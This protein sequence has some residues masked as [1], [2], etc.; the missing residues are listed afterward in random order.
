M[1]DKIKK[2]IELKDELREDYGIFYVAKHGCPEQPYAQISYEGFINLF[3]EGI[4]EE[5]FDSTEYPVK[6][7]KEVDGILFFTL[8]TEEEYEKYKKS[9]A[10]NTTK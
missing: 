4:K 10:N 6:L 8:L 7:K 3:N 1:I 2:I 5:R 9:R